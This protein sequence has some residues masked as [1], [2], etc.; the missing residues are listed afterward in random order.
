NMLALQATRTTPIQSRQQN[1]RQVQVV[2]Q[3][4]HPHTPHQF[5][6]RQQQQQ[7]TQ[8][9]NAQHF[10]FHQYG[11]RP[12]QSFTPQQYTPLKTTTVQQ[13]PRTTAT[14]SNQQQN[15]YASIAPRYTTTTQ[16]NVRST[17]FAP[18]QLKSNQQDFSHLNS[19]IFATSHLGTNNILGNANSFGWNQSSQGMSSFQFTQNTKQE[20]FFIA[21]FPCSDEDFTNIEKQVQLHKENKIA[22][23]PKKPKKPKK[24]TQVMDED[25]FDYGDDDE[26]E[27]QDDPNDQDYSFGGE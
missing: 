22:K 25:P 2:N 24:Q 16:Q 3:I 11:T 23:E 14:T 17:L 9:N 4:S 5:Q 18:T 7:I 8:A 20:E 12:Q 27:E 13:K 6:Q 26:F 15:S 1:L 19:N 21:V 10:M